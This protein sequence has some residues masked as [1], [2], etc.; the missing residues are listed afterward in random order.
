MSFETTIFLA[1]SEYLKLCV[2][3]GVDPVKFWENEP[4][5][6]YKYNP[7]SN[8]PCNGSVRRVWNGSHYE[9]VKTKKCL[10][11]KWHKCE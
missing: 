2:E 6:C 4:P 5:V 11:C 10:K 7:T 3:A 1:K 8:K 9:N